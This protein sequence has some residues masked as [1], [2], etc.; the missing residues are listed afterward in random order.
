MNDLLF[1]HDIV[2]NIRISSGI[3]GFICFSLLTL[4]SR[5]ESI[6]KEDIKPFVK[7]DAMVVGRY[8][9]L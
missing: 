2:P 1:G 5:K 7:G 3:E 8:N 4:I 9:V 6:L